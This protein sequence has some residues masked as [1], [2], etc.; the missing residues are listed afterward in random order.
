MDEQVAGWEVD[1]LEKGGF[2]MHDPAR[3]FLLEF[4]GLAWPI[5][6]QWEHVPSFLF[7]LIPTVAVFENDRFDE[8]SDIAEEQLYP[9]G[10]VLYGHYFLAIGHR[11]NLYLVM[12]DLTAY[13]SDPWAAFDRLLR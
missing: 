4:G 8:M 3:S 2:R 9:V 11:T 13:G 12:D 6:G 7:N 10:E 5:G 1:L